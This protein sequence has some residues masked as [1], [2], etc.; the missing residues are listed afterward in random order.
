MSDVNPNP[1]N[2]PAPV[3]PV[4]QTEGEPAP[5]ETPVQPVDG[6]PETTSPTPTP[7]STSGKSV[8]EVAKEVLAGHWGRGHKREERLELAGYSK[9][10]V[11]GELARLLGTEEYKGVENQGLQNTLDTREPA[12]TEPDAA[13]A[14]EAEATHR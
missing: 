10:A 2:E 6:A 8:E 12:D 13:A 5:A 4:P 3:E 11:Q 14:S 1:S 7:E 9:A